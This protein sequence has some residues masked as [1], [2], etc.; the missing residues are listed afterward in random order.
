VRTLLCC[1][2]V[3]AVA[4]GI[5]GLAACGSTPSP[6]DPG[7]LPVSAAAP[8]GVLVGAGDIGWCGSAGMALT[9]RLLDNIPGTVFTAG[10]NTYM[11]GTAQEFQECYDPHWGRHK[12]RTRPVA[13]NH[14]Y[15]SPGAGPYYSYFGANAGP[16]GQGYYSYTVGPWR[17]LALNSEIDL[18]H[19]SAQMSWLRNQ[20]ETHQGRCTAAIWHRPLF[21][22]G[23]NGGN[24]DMRD[25]WQTLYDAD[26]D[27]VIN[28]HEHMYERFARQSP[29]GRPDP[30]RGIR[31]FT[32]G[33]GGVPLSQAATV[34]ANSEV[35]ASTWGV[36]VFTFTDYG[37]AWEFKPADGFSFTDSG[38]GECH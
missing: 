34:Q 25:V 17:I 7:P 23:P 12:G 6:S 26:V 31:Q 13:G 21:T 22:S 38:V 9:A 35:R 28:G 30:A 27:L 37:Y 14:D 24:P 5:A 3:F 8:S 1:A 11:S 19:G 18:G 15:G 32:V 36:I 33:T 29:D 16:S 4:A 10:D 2:K 20:L